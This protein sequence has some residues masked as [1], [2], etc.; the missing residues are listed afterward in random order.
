MW[1]ESG[2]WAPHQGIIGEG[3]MRTEEVGG[4][5]PIPVRR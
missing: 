2:E 3:K 5:N 4:R 1:E